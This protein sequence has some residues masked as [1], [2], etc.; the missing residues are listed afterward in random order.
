ML[1]LALAASTAVT[2]A[3]A[4]PP[5]AVFTLDQVLNYPFPDN[6]VAANK[7]TAVAWTFA[8][9]GARNIYFAEAPEFKVPVEPS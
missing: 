7:G 2:P 3:Q 9:R 6:L 1:A 4:P 5:G 8:E